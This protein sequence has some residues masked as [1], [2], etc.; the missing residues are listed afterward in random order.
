MATIVDNN[1]PGRR[2]DAPSPPG[3]NRSP[4]PSDSVVY[5]GPVQVSRGSPAWWGEFPNE[6][7]VTIFRVLRTRTW[8]ELVQFNPKHGT[9]HY[10]EAA[11]EGVT[12]GAETVNSWE[13]SLGVS[14]GLNWGPLSAS[15][16]ATMSRGQQN[17][18]TVEL[19]Q[20]ITRTIT[21]DFPAG[22]DAEIVA[23]QQEE[24]FT[25]E[26]WRFV[27]DNITD[28]AQVTPAMV[29]ECKA[30][31]EASLR[32]NSIPKKARHYFAPAGLTMNTSQYTTTSY[33]AIANAQAKL[34]A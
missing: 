4:P 20:S 13:T 5:Q 8:N 19:S 34:A 30:A 11:T 12:N 15:I 1:D 6:A 23:W 10:S 16:T 2:P 25:R 22:V 3:L 17:H 14:A 26:G 27:F 21:F 33:P 29:Q 28:L 32:D 18:V 9:G 31:V 7:C 24:G